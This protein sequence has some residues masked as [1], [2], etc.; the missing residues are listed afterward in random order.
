MSATVADLE[1]A[2]D[3]GEFLMSDAPLNQDESRTL[4]IE[5]QSPIG[6]LTVISDGD[7][8][9]ALYMES[10]KH[11]KV[12]TSAW[13]RA[14]DGKCEA[15]NM[16]RAQLSEY[17]AGARTTF[18]LPLRASGTNVQK[19]VWSGTGAYSIWGNAQLR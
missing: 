7:V 14:D 9:T 1:T 13:T 16:A 3:T 19:S 5:M 6:L 2:I 12:N 4:F 8:V 11:A 17:F 18:S 10:H 15:L